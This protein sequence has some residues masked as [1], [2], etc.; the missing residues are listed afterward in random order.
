MHQIFSRP[1]F[2]FLSLLN[3]SVSFER[4]PWK[5]RCYIL[6]NTTDWNILTKHKHFYRGKKS[7]I[8]LRNNELARNKKILKPNNRKQNS[9]KNQSITFWKMKQK[10]IT[11][12]CK[13]ITT[14]TTT[15]RGWYISF[16]NS[17]IKWMWMN[18]DFE[19]FVLR[20]IVS[21]KKF[22]SFSRPISCGTG[23]HYLN[24]EKGNIDF[25]VWEYW[26]IQKWNQTNESTRIDSK[27]LQLNENLEKKTTVK[28][29]GMDG[30]KS[31][32][33]RCLSILSCSVSYTDL[34]QLHN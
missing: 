32:I 28:K 10:Q 13:K 8:I 12:N 2:W 17:K 3:L 24:K 9:I 19:F 34:N 1:E 18:N 7:K 29:N 26:K 33:N 16:I 27:I 6:S 30:K 23:F 31:G 21:V 5:K 20:A 22:L 15:T 4:K 25:F 14:T 11:E